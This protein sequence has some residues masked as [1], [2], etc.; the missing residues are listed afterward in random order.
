MLQKFPTNKL[1]PLPFV[2]GSAN[3]FNDVMLKVNS[4]WGTKAPSNVAD[5]KAFKNENSNSI[6]LL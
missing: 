1:E 4:V 5:W 6:L 2:Q 3:N